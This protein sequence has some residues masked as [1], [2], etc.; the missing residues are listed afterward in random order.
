[1]RRALSSAWIAAC[2]VAAPALATSPVA[3][4]PTG[5]D[6]L[7]EQGLMMFEGALGACREVD[8]GTAAAMQAHMQRLRPLMREAV[9]TAFADVP[10]L[11]QPPSAQDTQ[12]TREIAANVSAQLADVARTQGAPF[13]QAMLQRMKTADA[14]ELARRARTHYDEAQ[15][16]ARQQA[17]P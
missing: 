1:M 14:D 5:L 10:E 4:P 7:T 3:A 2:L 17:K 15:A 16:K 8:A 6:V 11:R 12:T 13:C 9:Q